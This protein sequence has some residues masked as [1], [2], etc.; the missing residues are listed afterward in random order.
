MYWGTMYVEDIHGTRRWKKKLSWSSS[1]EKRI[2]EAIR[3]TSIESG[4]EEK[5]NKGRTFWT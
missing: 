2:D 1:E 3:E 5:S 4:H